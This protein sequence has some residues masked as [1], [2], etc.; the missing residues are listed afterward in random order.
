MSFGWNHVFLRKKVEYFVACNKVGKSSEHSLE[1][2]S[3][4]SLEIWSAKGYV[5]LRPQPKRFQCI[6]GLSILPRSLLCSAHV[7][8]T[9]LRLIYAM[10]KGQYLLTRLSLLW[11]GLLFTEINHRI[12]SEQN[13][14]TFLSFLS[15]PKTA[16]EFCLLACL[17]LVLFFFLKTN[18]EKLCCCFDSRRKESIQWWKLNMAVSSTCNA[19]RDMNSEK[20]EASWTL[21]LE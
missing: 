13:T 10:E 9:C 16:W 5:T 20:M 8:R 15:L 3:S 19:F 2:H 6:V 17:I 18:K 4:G 7:L 1:C 11:S 14:P 21:P 12:P